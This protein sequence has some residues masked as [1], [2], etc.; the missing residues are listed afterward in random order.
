MPD[1]KTTCVLIASIIIPAGYL[2]LNLSALLTARQWGVEIS[3]I[4]DAVFWLWSIFFNLLPPA[5]LPW[6]VTGVIVL[7]K[8]KYSFLASIFLL[9]AAT[10]LTNPG[11][12]RVYLPLAALHFRRFLI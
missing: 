7:R 8:Y 2:L 11:P 9:A 12:W 1:K 5:L 3:G 10:V 6:T 4:K